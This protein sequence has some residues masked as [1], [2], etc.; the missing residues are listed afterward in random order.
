MD[1]LH[2]KDQK[3]DELERLVEIL[4]EQFRT[5]GIPMADHQA[6]TA[7][8]LTT[9]TTLDGTPPPSTSREISWTRGSPECSLSTRIRPA[10][11]DSSEP[12]RKKRA[13]RSEDV[14]RQSEALPARP[15]DDGPPDLTRESAQGGEGGEPS[16]VQEGTAREEPDIVVIEADPDVTKAIEP[17]GKSLTVRL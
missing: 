3:I 6:S 2:A 5:A 8:G 4:R 16:L 10:R 14:I 7:E 17:H 1:R 9:R 13:L 11:P 12:H 15:Y